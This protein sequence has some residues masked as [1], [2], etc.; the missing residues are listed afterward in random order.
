MEITENSIIG[1]MVG[2][3]SKITVVQMELEDGTVLEGVVTD[4]APVVD[5]TAQDIRYGKTAITEYGVTVGK[6]KAQRA[7]SSSLL[8][9]PGDA[10]VIQFD[11]DMY[12]YAAFQC[13][14]TASGAIKYASINNKI[15][16]VDGAEISTITKDVNTKSINLNFTNDSEDT[17]EILY[18]TYRDDT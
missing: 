3:T 9:K 4:D 18:T 6:Y 17:Y 1:N 14:I 5:A 7:M 2:G 11:D 16:S 15:V 8:V 10:C 13:A 12:D